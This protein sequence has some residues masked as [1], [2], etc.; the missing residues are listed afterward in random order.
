[1]S[2][3]AKVFPPELDVYFALLLLPASLVKVWLLAALARMSLLCTRVHHAHSSHEP[4]WNTVETE[5]AEQIRQNSRAV[6]QI[7]HLH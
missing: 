1:M 6:I 5:D 4:S 2:G 3:T 7:T